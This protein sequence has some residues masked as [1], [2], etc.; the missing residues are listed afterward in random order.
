MVKHRTRRLL[1]VSMTGALF[2]AACG[3]DDSGDT[4]SSTTEAG[5]AS[6]ASSAAEVKPRGSAPASWMRGCG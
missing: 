6:T 3:G 5:G 4:A 1:A 2:L